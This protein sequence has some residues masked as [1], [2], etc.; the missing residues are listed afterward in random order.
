MEIFII[1]DDRS[2]LRSLKRLIKSAGFRNVEIFESAESFL[3]QVK[4]GGKSGLVFIDLILPGMGGVALNH[5]LQRL[6]YAGK[7]VFIS[8]LQN[9]LKHARRECPD[10]L[11]FLS[12]PFET[13][14]IL[15]VVRSASDT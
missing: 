9:Q 1:D 2:V 11:A 4:P 3:D 5:K 12:K 14:D 8:A 10:A 7:V 6:G 13:G 15:S